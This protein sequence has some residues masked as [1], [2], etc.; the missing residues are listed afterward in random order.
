VKV[1]HKKNKTIIRWGIKWKL[2]ATITLLMVS[3]LGIFTYF[4]VSWQKTLIEN[5]LDKRIA[6]MKENLTERGKNFVK[7]LSQQAEKNI[8]SFNFSAVI[9]DVKNGVNANREIMYAVL[10][11]SS[12]MIF[13]HTLNPDLTQTQLTEEKDREALKKPDMTVSEYREKNESLIEIVSH[14][15]ISTEIWGVLRVIFTLRDLVKETAS[16]RKQIKKDTNRMIW[17]TALAALGAMGICFLMVMILSTR[18]SEPLIDLTNSAR[19]LSKGNFTHTIDIVRKDEIGV[20]AGAMNH[21]V[22]DLSEIIRGNISTSQSL[23]EGTVDQTSSLEVTSSLLE[24][25]SLMTRQN[26]ENANKADDFMKETNQVVVRA[27]ESMNLLTVSMEDMSATSKESFQIIKTI[28][29]IAFQTNLLAL[30]AAV[31]A[32]RAG[33]GGLGFA[34]VA[35]EVRNLAMRSAQAAR[36]TASLIEDTVKKINDGNQLVALANEGFREVADNAAKV[37][38]LVSEISAASNEQNKRISQI[39]DAVD[40]MNSIIR[41]N[42]ASAKE[43][44]SSMALF[45]VRSEKWEVGSEKWEVGNGN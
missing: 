13:V 27:N 36:N 5:E 32:A 40:R 29:E 35:E 14:I 6:L 34:V 22:R 43:L 17:K 8:A 24:E 30:N 33:E 7:N 16:S 37:A 42:N 45:K 25:M 23:S 15:Q 2:M 9:E 44:A 20:L 41:R 21:M 28:D 10:T 38:E 26:A 39:N 18:F 11:D 12:G 19:E 3:M 4:Q 31:E 1:R